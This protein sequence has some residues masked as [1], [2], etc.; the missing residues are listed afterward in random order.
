MTN[1][2]SEKKIKKLEIPQINTLNF[3]KTVRK[4]IYS[5]KHNSPKVDKRNIQF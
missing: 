4:Q 3:F 1:L 5:K 2:I